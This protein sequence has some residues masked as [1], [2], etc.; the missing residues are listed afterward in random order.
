VNR[1][2]S[3]G[4]FPVI[5]AKAGIQHC[6]TLILVALRAGK[7]AKRVEKIKKNEQE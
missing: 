4:M 5:P 6:C 7:R 2:L 1:F 3:S